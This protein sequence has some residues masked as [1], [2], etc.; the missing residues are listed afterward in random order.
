MIKVIVCNMSMQLNGDV[1]AAFLSSYGGVDYTLIPSAHGTS[2]SDYSFTMILDRGGFNSIPHIISYQDTTMAVIVE[3][4]KLLYWNCKQLSHFSRSCHQKNTI[5]TNKTTA[6][7]ATTD[8]TTMTTTTTTTTTATTKTKTDANPE[9]GDQP[10]KE[11]GWT[12]VKG[13][14]RRNHK[15]IHLQLNRQH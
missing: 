15:Q 6:T 4:R 7:I 8:T 13:K 2:Y 14:K 9:T 1:L 5:T 11:E 10:D 3:G 12:P